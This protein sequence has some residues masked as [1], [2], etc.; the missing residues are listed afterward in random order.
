M[1]IKL[2]K[3]NNKFYRLFKTPTIASKKDYLAIIA[4]AEK[5]IEEYKKFILF[6]KKIMKNIK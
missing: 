2:A 4:W 3:I 5:E 1:K 6:Y